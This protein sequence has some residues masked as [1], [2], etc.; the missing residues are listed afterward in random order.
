MQIPG[1]HIETIHNPNRYTS[2][3]ID[4]ACAVARRLARGKFVLAEPP[5]R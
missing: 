1:V 5:G 4:T 2:V 3:Q